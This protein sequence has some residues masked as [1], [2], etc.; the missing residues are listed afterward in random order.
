MKFS[1]FALA[2]LSPLATFAGALVPRQNVGP[3]GYASL[4]GGTGMCDSGFTS[5]YPY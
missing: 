3:V 1:T 4:N 5:G 2:A